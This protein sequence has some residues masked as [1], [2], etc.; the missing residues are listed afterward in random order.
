MFKKQYSINCWYVTYWK[1][2][3]LGKNKLEIWIH[4][5]PMNLCLL[6]TYHHISTSSRKNVADDRRQCYDI[7][8]H[9]TNYLKWQNLFLWNVC[10]D[11]SLSFYFGL[12]PIE[13]ESHPL[14]LASRWSSLAVHLYIHGQ[15]G[16]GDGWLLTYVA[17]SRVRTELQICAFTI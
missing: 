17:W 5:I 4:I 12:C 10:F 3:K 9:D 15:T 7:Y 11:C 8:Q 2:Q 16:S 14:L 13:R 1:Y 6:P